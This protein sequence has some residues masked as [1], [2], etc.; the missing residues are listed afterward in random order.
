LDRGGIYRSLDGGQ[1]WQRASSGLSPESSVTD[2]VF[3]PTNPA[4]VL[5][6]AVQQ[7]GVYRSVDRGTTWVA[8]SDGL[9]SR[10]VNALAITSDGLHL[11]A[12]TEGSG[13][14]RLDLNGK[15]P[16]SVAAPAEDAT[17]SPYQ[18]S[19][20]AEAS[21][22]PTATQYQ[23]RFGTPSP[24]ASST[25]RPPLCGRAL[26]PIGLTVVVLVWKRGRF[27]ARS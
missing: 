12:A 21:A 16:L 2:I 23:Y 24:S 15:P 25:E 19:G 5:Y 10:A 8:I 3:D 17:T 14:F 26:V 7:S 13:A 4:E 11:Y 1:A 20:A 22:P 6:A 18:Y 27:S 9:L